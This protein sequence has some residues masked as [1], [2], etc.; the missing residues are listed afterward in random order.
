M[1]EGGGCTERV[2][3]WRVHGQPLQGWK[4]EK[5]EGVRGIQLT[6][7]WVPEGDAVEERCAHTDGGDRTSI[8]RSRWVHNV[9]NGQCVFG[10]FEFV[11]WS[12][13]Q[14]EN[15]MPTR[16]FLICI[17]FA[18]S[19][20]PRLQFCRFRHRVHRAQARATPSDLETF[21]LTFVCYIPASG[22]APS[23]TCVSPFCQCALQ[24]TVSLLSNYWA[25]LP[26]HSLCRGIFEWA[27]CT[28]CGITR[29]F[30]YDSP[31]RTSLLSDYKSTDSIWARPY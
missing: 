18:L 19:F 9:N 23:V 31:G 13:N 15:P 1:P 16:E 29:R 30:R 12:P 2:Q 6:F 4:V 7:V 22:L 27:A 28:V 10:T 5:L 11:V 17:I 20:L 24:A 26:Q 21:L 25:S 14:Q 3:E 8:D